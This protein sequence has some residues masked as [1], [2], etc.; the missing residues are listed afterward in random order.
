[1]TEC[2]QETFAFTAHFSRRVEAGFT[3][4]RISS[5]GGAILLREA[6]RKIGLL[7]RLEVC[8]RDR[9]HPKRIMHRLREML[10]QRIFGIAMGYEDLNDHEQL[11]T[12]PLVALLSGKSD[13][14][15]DLAGKSTLNRLELVGRSERYHKID[16]SAEAIDR[17]LVDLYLESHPQP[18]EKV[19]LDLDAT[20]IPLYGHQPERFFH[21]YYDSYCYLPLYI[22]ADDQLL[23]VRLR[24]SN[25][26]ASAGSLTEARRIVEQLRT[27]WPGV[28]IVLRADSGFCR[29]EIMAWCEA[30]QVDY[31]FGLARNERLCRT[32][33]ASMEQARR[34]HESSGKPTRFFTEFAYRTLSSWSRERR[35]VAKAEYLE[36]G[37][38][39][40]FVVTSLSSEEWPAQELYEKLYC[41][42]GE[43]EN[44]I[45]E[46]LYLFADRLST[47]QM[48]SNQL[49]LY[50]S[51]LAYTLVEAL[52]RLALR[53]TD[54]AEAQ[55]DT[56][57]LKL[58]KI[59]TL[60]RVS[61]RRVLLSM[62][63]A[64][65]WK[66]LFTHAF[67]VLRC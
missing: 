28:K 43:M 62:S 41:A 31:L 21:G 38:N 17:L 47:A 29:E 48:A 50:F 9:R 63:N 15:E 7:R 55:V 6:D 4:G 14:E 40:R 54:W 66:S 67:R 11:R 42:R 59:G 27:R 33:K 8:F 58:F 12:D 65:P 52:R 1:M 60:V 34:L 61:V 36:R 32:I 19:V 22:F 20:D 56:L 26:D 23:G 25:Q 16:Y 39:P 10:A 49:R 2:S 53:G 35:V 13:L 30:H 18:P 57:R 64:Y 45:K 24:P 51:A 3:A 37:E 44:R 46:Q 5:D